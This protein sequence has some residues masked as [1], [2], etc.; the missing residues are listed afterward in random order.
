MHDRAT[1]AG[2]SPSDGCQLL[3]TLRHRRRPSIPPKKFIDSENA[4]G[5]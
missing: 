1:D 2:A 3:G 5:F 4:R